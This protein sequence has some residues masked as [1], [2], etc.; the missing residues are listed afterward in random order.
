MLW[1]EQV[2]KLGVRA[3]GAGSPNVGD[4]IFDV[5]AHRAVSTQPS[6]CLC[7]Q[8]EIHKC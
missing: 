7:R 1:T 5:R 2:A 6:V 4:G 3:G 8:L